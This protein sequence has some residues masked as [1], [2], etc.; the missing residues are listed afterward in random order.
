MSLASS[1]EEEFGRVKARV[2]GL[3]ARFDLAWKNL[4][5]QLEPKELQ[6]ILDLVQRAH[7]QAQYTIAHGDLPPGQ[8]RCPGSWPMA[9]RCCTWARPSP[10]RNRWTSWR[11][12]CSRTAACWAVAS[13][14]CWT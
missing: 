6:A 4:R 14:N 11:P 9:C 1:V 2:D 13:G 8:P 12:R 10:C 5:N 7:D 3:I